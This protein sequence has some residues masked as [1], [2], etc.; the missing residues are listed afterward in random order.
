MSKTRVFLKLPVGIGLLLT[1]LA[2]Q[3]NLDLTLSEQKV[4]L[5]PREKSGEMAVAY[6]P[7][8]TIQY[9]LLAKNTGNEVMTS[10][11]ITDPLPKGVI[12]IIGSVTGMGASQS[13]SIDNGNSYAA[14]PVMYTAIDNG[15]NVQKPATPQMVTHI[16][17]TLNQR[18]PAGGFVNLSFRAIV[19]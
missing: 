17:W 8:D 14:W 11:V 1:V 10:P 15:K 12:P 16:R 5:L 2:A 19:K 4:N 13:F 7:G 18:L 3:P 6:H 9:N